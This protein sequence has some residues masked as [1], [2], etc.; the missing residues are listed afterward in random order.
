[1][2]GTRPLRIEARG[3][4]DIGGTIDADGQA[5]RPGQDGIG[6]ALLNGFE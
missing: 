6:G 1:V 3:A 4:C 5:G 2:T